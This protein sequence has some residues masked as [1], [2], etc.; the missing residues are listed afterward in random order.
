MQQCCAW[1]MMP[2]V[3]VLLSQTSAAQAT[4]STGRRDDCGRQHG[5]VATQNALAELRY[6]SVCDAHR[7][8]PTIFSK[9]P[10][11]AAGAVGVRKIQSV[12]GGRSMDQCIVGTDSVQ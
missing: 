9:S 2:T 11:K 3:F 4:H 1:R 10:R 7:A 12:R 5:A 6:L 8:A